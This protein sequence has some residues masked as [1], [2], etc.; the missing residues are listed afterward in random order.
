LIGGLINGPE[1]SGFSSEHIMKES[2][3]GSE[4]RTWKWAYLGEIITVRSS[5]PMGA[6]R[7]NS[8]PDR[9]CF[10]RG[11]RGRGGFLGGR[12]LSCRRRTSLEPA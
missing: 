11:K 12:Y 2:L 4:M 8:D 7:E 5:A 3:K 1:F 10:M 6:P 9:F